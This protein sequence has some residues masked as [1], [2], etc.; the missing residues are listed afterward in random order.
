M[1]KHGRAGK[2]GNNHNNQNGRKGK[3]RSNNGNNTPRYLQNETVIEFSRTPNN[4]QRYKR[5]MPLTE[6]QGILY[7]TILAKTLTFAL[8]PMGTGKSRVAIEVGCE[9]LLARKVDQLILTTSDFEI[10]QPLGPVPGDVQEKIAPRMRPMRQLLE[11]ILGRSHLECLI[12]NEKVVFEPLGQ[13]LG[14]TFD[15]AFVIAD[16][17]QIFTP[18]Q[19]KAL[20]SR[21]GQNTRVVLAGDYKDQNY[22]GKT[23]GLEDAYYRMR[24]GPDVGVVVFGIE[25]IVRSD[26]C[27]FVTKAYRDDLPVTTR[28]DQNGSF[29]PDFLNIS[30]KGDVSHPTSNI[31]THGNMLVLDHSETQ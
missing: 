28:Q 4:G 27:K 22:L 12:K 14:L 24:N 1:T 6:N 19:M 30:A 16:E 18:I 7:N 15:N 3:G 9:L 25:D 17:A 13:I 26:F 11:K 5:F 8:G 29:V 2:F 20:L 21:T 10:E 31:M 23:S